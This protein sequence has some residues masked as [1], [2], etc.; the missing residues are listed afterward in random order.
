MKMELIVIH[1]LDLLMKSLAFG[2]DW[3]VKLIPNGMSFFISSF[4]YNLSVMGDA[5]MECP[6]C[7]YE[8]RVIK[9]ALTFKA[10]SVLAKTDS[11]DLRDA[12]AIRDR[13]AN[14]CGWVRPGTT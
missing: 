7:K 10:K 13:V 4:P 6:K 3:W 8:N 2:E 5:K 1:N 9:Y 12:I 11:I 14:V